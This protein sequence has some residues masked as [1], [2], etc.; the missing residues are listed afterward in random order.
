MT[1]EPCLPS[2]ATSRVVMYSAQSRN[3]RQ[4]AKQHDLDVEHGKA[5]WW[6]QNVTAPTAAAAIERA[7]VA[8]LPGTNISAPWTRAGREALKADLRALGYSATDGIV[9]L[10]DVNDLWSRLAIRSA[11][12]FVGWNQEL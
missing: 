5:S 4:H 11:V 7:A 2:A 1:P 6:Y 8:G 9:H 12:I 10:C 3:H